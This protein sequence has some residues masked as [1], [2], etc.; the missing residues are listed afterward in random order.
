M[1]SLT[2]RWG[3]S[4]DETIVHGE[5]PRPHLVRNSFYSLNGTW[6]YAI[7]CEAEINEYDGTILVPFSPET[8]LSGVERMV[9]PDDYLHY[10]KK[11]VLPEGFQKERVLLHFG[12]VDQ[13]CKVSLNGKL[14]GEHKGGYL[15]FSFDVTEFLVSG[16]NVLTLCV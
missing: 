5:Y 9:T 8:K 4:L 10:R 2:S 16:E 1:N 11:F 6:E 14:V 3:R 12:A 13:E 15:A 7:N